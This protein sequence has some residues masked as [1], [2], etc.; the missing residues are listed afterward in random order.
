M[1]RSE[2]RLFRLLWLSVAAAVA[3]IALKTVAYL[4]TGSVGL[5]SDAL[6]SVVNLV[7]AVVALGAL[8]WA[9]KPAD[10]EHPHGHTKA[11]YFSAGAEGMMIFVAAVAIAGT[12]VERLLHPHPIDQV[13]LGLLVS[14]AASV[15][16]LAVGL[17]LV[18]AGRRHRSITLEADGKHLLTDVWTSVGVVAAVGAVALTGWSQL[19]PLIALAV[20]VN[21]VRTGTDLIRRSGA[22]LM[23]RALDT[24][25]QDR[26]NEVLAAFER[27]GVAFHAVRTR[28]SG[29]RGFVSLHLLVPGAWTVQRGHDKA[30]EVEAALRTALPHITVL[31]HLEPIE[32]PVSYADTGLDRTDIPSPSGA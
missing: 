20:A 6:E 18:R 8:R 4:V 29:S 9:S 16:N 17:L 5:L 23:D 22:G 7:A 2:S 10:E 15:L 30:E 27:E 28:Q 12:A 14:T 21:I 31:T 25:E 13:G 1:D 11:E 19:D 26:I 3:T 32:D 24:D